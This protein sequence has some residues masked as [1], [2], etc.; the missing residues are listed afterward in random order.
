[1]DKMMPEIARR[2][3]LA[4]ISTYDELCGIAGYTR[5]L[6]GYLEQDFDIEVFDLDQY[7]LRHTH[8]RVIR[9]GDAHIKAFAAR[10][11]EFDFV[12]IQLEHGTLGRTV[13]LILRRLGWLLAA[14]PAVSV[15][16]H[17]ILQGQPVDW[18]GVT[19]A[20]LTGRLIRAFD[21]AIGTVRDNM[22]GWRCYRLLRRTQRRKPLHVI[23]HTRRDMRTMRDV[24]QFRHVHHHPLAFVSPADAAHVRATTTREMFP[25][26]RTLPADAKLI[27][28][29]GFLSEYKGFETAIQALRQLPDN[30]H[31]LIFGGV[32]PQTIKRHQKLDPYIAQLL[33]AGRI[34]QTIIDQITS[35]K[36]NVALNL[37][38]AGLREM[39]LHYPLD[40]S[41]RVHFMGAQSDDEFIR[42]M[43][44][45]D[46]VVLPYLEVG[47]SSSGPI[48]MALDMGCRVLASRTTAFLQFGRYF[49]GEVEMFD[50]GNFHE[51]ALR[52]RA[53]RPAPA[54]AQRAYDTDSNRAVYIAA[55]TPAGQPVRE[56]V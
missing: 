56:S 10:L 34:D 49:P 33:E 22:L 9:M 12:N 39:L 28:T 46:A 6:V 51:L 35:T 32:H 19:K 5:A 44:V 2:P 4:I 26:L 21:I 20:A 25:I 27:G 24:Q 7:L 38:G 29:F 42:A 52:L 15:T 55:N 53:D 50:I 43:A 14:A 13:P 54:P 16:M 1:M 8:K 48:S 37:D 17:T 36:A 3:R 18:D 30:Y 40:L 31:L 11:R 45:C 47:Q 23:V 41:R